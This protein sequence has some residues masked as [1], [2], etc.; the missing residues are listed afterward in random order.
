MSFFL[1]D[2]LIFTTSNAGN[3][4][5]GV[6]GEVNGIN[7]HVNGVDGL[8]NG[9]NGHADAGSQPKPPSLRLSFAEYQRISNLLVLHLR[10]SEEGVLPFAPPRRFLHHTRTCSAYPN[11]RTCAFN[12]EK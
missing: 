12:V 11:R 8:V 6:N 9:V 2:A 4:P 1:T 10:R 5:N 7:G 3:I